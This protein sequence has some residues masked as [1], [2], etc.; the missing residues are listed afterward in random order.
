MNLEILDVRE[1]NLIGRKEVRFRVLHEGR[2]TPTIESVKKALSAKLSSP[3]DST[4]V[5]GLWSESG[6]PVT[7]GYARI[8]PSRKEAEFYEPEHTLRLNLPKEERAKAL[9]ELKRIRTE[10]KAARRR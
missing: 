6:R 10:R 9:E 8:Y 5:V 4:I 1:N 3:L 2:P 7:N